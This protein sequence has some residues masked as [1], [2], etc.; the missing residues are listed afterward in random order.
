[1]NFEDYQTAEQVLGMD[2]PEWL[3]EKE[4]IFHTLVGDKK[5]KIK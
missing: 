5:I 2:D 1:M 4:I 3:S